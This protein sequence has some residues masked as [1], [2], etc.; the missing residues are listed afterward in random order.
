MKNILSTRQ[1]CLEMSHFVGSQFD[2]KLFRL[3]RRMILHVRYTIRWMLFSLCREPAGLHEPDGWSCDF[4]GH[5]RMFDMMGKVV[6]LIRYG[7]TFQLCKTYQI[8]PFNIMQITTIQDLFEN[9]Q[10]SNQTH[11]QNILWRHAICARL[12]CCYLQPI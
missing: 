10:H 8:Y 11:V 9:I 3:G 6:G 5:G 1:K 12:C 4:E 2:K 7:K